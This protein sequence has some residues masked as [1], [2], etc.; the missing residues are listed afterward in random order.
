V[1]T[2]DFASIQSIFIGFFQINYLAPVGSAIES[3]KLS[4]EYFVKLALANAFDC[5]LQGYQILIYFI[6]T[7]GISFIFNIYQSILNR[8]AN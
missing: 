5:H 6:N 1:S 3:A 7:L 2:F 4:D 8:S